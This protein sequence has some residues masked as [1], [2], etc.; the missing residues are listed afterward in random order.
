[1]AN[2]PLEGGDAPD[3][4]QHVLLVRVDERTKTLLRELQ[5]LRDTTVTKVEFSPVKNLVYGLS[6]LLLTSVVVALLSL[7]IRSSG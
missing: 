5:L 6:A 7:V 1:M 2:S 4:S 3:E